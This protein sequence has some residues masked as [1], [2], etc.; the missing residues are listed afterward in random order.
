VLKR[1]AASKVWAQKQEVDRHH[2]ATRA[3]RFFGIWAIYAISSAVIS[4]AV[5]SNL[6]ASKVWAA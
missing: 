3:Q 5:L 1:L 2:L 4:L 6:T